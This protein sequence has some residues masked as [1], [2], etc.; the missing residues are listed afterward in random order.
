[1][2]GRIR[3]VNSQ[4]VGKGLPESHM[5]FLPPEVSEELKLCPV[6]STSSTHCFLNGSASRLGPLKWS[7]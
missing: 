4:E 2:K 7:L 6:W 1:M 3:V 5:L